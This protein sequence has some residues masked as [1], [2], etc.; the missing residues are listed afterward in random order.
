M[1]FFIVT[2]T[3]PPDWIE[4]DTCGFVSTIQTTGLERENVVLVRGEIPKTHESLSRGGRK[5][6]GS[7]PRYLS[8]IGC[9]QH[10]QRANDQELPD[11]P[12]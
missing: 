2:I 5:Q 6:P 8:G 11:G 9:E 3:V 1:S 10:W 7:G 12:P 4:A